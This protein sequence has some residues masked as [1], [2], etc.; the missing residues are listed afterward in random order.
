MAQKSC[1]SGARPAPP[2]PATRKPRRADH[3]TAAR[4]PPALFPHTAPVP[5]G[6][7]LEDQRAWHRCPHRAGRARRFAPLARAFGSAVAA[8]VLP[9]RPA[10]NPRAACR[11]ASGP[12]RSILEPVANDF[13]ARP[14]GLSIPAS[15]TPPARP[16]PYDREPPP[17]PSTPNPTMGS[18]ASGAANSAMPI[19][20]L[21]LPRWSAPPGRLRPRQ[22]RPLRHA[23]TADLGE[24]HS[25]GWRSSA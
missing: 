10:G 16:D 7:E 19:G 25:D 4:H 2:P 18:D 12:S 23:V 21:A 3:P 6:P 17:R 5:A 14:R 20:R 13:Y 15:A 9:R 11:A 1:P 24:H 22:G 8:A